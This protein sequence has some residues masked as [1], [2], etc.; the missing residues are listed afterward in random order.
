MPKQELPLKA[1]KDLKGLIFSIPFQQRGYKWTQNNV[2]EL[3]CDIK[4]FIECKNTSKRVYCLQPLAVVNKGDNVYGVLD[5]Q[6]R[7]TT[8]FL[9]YMFLENNNPPYMFLFERDN[10]EGN[11]TYPNRFDFLKNIDFAKREK[12]NQNIDCFYIYEAYQQIIDTF[13]EWDSSVKDSFKQLLNAN[14]EEKS[15]QVIWYEVEENKEHETFRNLN[16]GKIQLTN[17]ELIKALL[18]NS[19]SG[20]PDNERI[21]TASQFEQIEREMQND[22]FWYM[23]N[24]E[25]VKR[26]Q[27]RM[28]MLFN[29]VSQCKQEDYDLDPR[30]SF[31]HYFDKPE[32]GT[33]SEKW[34]K[35]RHTF[36]R[37]KDLYSDIYC[38]HYVGF[39]TYHRGSNSLE[40]LKKLLEKCENKKHQE[41]VTSFKN[42]I[43]TI[44]RKSKMKDGEEL[45]C[46]YDSVDDFNYNVPK[47]DLRKLFLMHNIE[48]LLRKYELHKGETVREKLMQDFEHLP[49][50]LF[51]KQDWDIEHI[52][53]CT[54]SDFKK[55]TDRND[56]LDSIKEDLGEKY[57]ADII[58]KELE[59]KYNADKKVESFN[60]LYKHIMQ[61]YEKTI[62]DVIPDES[63]DAMNKKD[64][65]QIGNITLLD[66][67][68]NRSYHN[69]LFP[70]KRRYIIVADG[71]VDITNDLENKE[72]N[73]V[74][75]PICTRQVFTKAYNKRASLNLNVWTQTDADAYVKDMEQ[76]LEY[77]F[78]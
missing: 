17:T 10:D 11:S 65:M 62:A 76:K 8:L 68:T 21:E 38:Y 35:V 67:R 45:S 5:G 7:L 48:T 6:Q 37:F 58:A 15:V 46:V 39:L 52:A 75:V 54:D 13:D 28:D 36:L 3:L 49:F 66:S 23:F 22:H 16:S 40:N 72:V 59:N 24:S 56:W 77:Y 26:G 9:L 55:E 63:D 71:L 27:T 25:D 12:A 4:D 2:K 64:K 50:N 78:K 20:L 41:L 57:K 60:A 42:E 44:L 74:Y 73:K 18:L 29:L 47:P 51:H 32:Y 70:R 19:A 14:K 33:L 31:R 43:R 69:A 1:L 61:Q 53:S 30:W 34:K